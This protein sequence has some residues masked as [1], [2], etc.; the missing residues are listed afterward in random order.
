MDLV[1]NNPGSTACHYTQ[2]GYNGRMDV[3]DVADNP[4]K[5]TQFVIDIYYIKI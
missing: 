3:A 2:P 1:I 5:K 4:Y